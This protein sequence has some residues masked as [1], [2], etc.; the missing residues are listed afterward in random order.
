MV[1]GEVPTTV[2]PGHALDHEIDLMLGSVERARHNSWYEGD[3]TAAANDQVLAAVTNR[4]PLDYAAGLG[5]DGDR[6]R[7]AWAE[8]GLVT[9]VPPRS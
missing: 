3:V 1:R 6:S 9:G 2:I 5:L 4:A 8:G 7:N